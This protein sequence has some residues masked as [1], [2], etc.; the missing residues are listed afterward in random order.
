MIQK[1]R[2]N[3]DEKISAK[4]IG[5]LLALARFRKGLS[6]YEVGKKVGLTQQTISRYEKGMIP[7]ADFFRVCQACGVKVKLVEYGETGGAE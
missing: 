5:T 1:P 4:A 6:Q 3:V 7:L 2:L